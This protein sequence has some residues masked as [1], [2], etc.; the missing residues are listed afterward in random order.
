[1]S[2]RSSSLETARKV[3]FTSAAV[4]KASATSGSST[5]TFVP[6]AYRAACLPRTPP[7]KSYSARMLLLRRDLVL[8]RFLILALFRSCR[9]P[10]AY[11]ADSLSTLCVRYHDQAPKVRAA[12]IQ[13]ALLRFGMIRVVD[14]YRQRIPENRTCLRERDAVLFQVQSC[15]ARIPLES[16]GHSGSLLAQTCKRQRKRI[17]LLRVLGAMFTHLR[18]LLVLS[19]SGRPEAGSRFPVCSCLCPCC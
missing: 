5:T 8:L 7:L 14:R 6:E 11:D 2:R 15:L 10:R 1:M 9:R 19:G 13:K 18:C 4:G 3:L 17:P 16:E 12:H